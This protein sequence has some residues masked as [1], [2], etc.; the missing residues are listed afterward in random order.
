MSELFNPFAFAVGMVALVNPCGFALL[1]A[2]LGFFMGQEDDNTSRIVALNRAQGVGLA[3]SLGFLTV[4]GLLGLVF[5]GLWNAIVEWL[6][7][8]NMALGV[9]LV[10]LGVAML[11][12]FQLVLKIPKLEKGTG[13]TSFSSMFLFGISYALASLSCTIGLFLTAVGT[14]A[15]TGGFSKQLGGFLSYGLGMGLLATVLTLAVAFGKRGLVNR[16]RTILPKINLISGVLLLIVG[17]YMVLYGIW[18]LQI[19][20]RAPGEVWPWLDSLMLGAQGFQS[21]LTSWFEADLSVLGKIFSRTSALGWVFTIVNLGLIVAGFA[22][23]FGRQP[24]VQ[25][26]SESAKAKVKSS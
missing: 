23:R 2:Y 21:G 11:R 14:S 9:G 4:F 3:M 24:S 26:S 25:T 13:S 22:A 16:F 18:E 20:N 8:F 6:P 10:V 1:P 15:T 17:P 12:G 5:S 19:F 7:Y